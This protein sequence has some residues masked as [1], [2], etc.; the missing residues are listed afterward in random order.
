MILG[1][2]SLKGGV[3][4]GTRTC[5]CEDPAS[6]VD[7]K[8]LRESVARYEHSLLVRM[9]HNNI[10]S[11]NIM[12]PF[13]SRPVWGSGCLIMN[14][15]CGCAGLGCLY[16]VSCSGTMV[17][18]KRSK[19][20]IWTRRKTILACAVAFT[21]EE[22]DKVLLTSMYL[23]IGNSLRALPSQLGE[24]TMWRALVQVQHPSLINLQSL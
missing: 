3:S 12:V 7:Y 22:A 20:S 11:C 18:I 9:A 15:A 14:H 13:V 5:S 24:L 8:S 16:V 4:R 2:P 6:T 19:I 17:V 21:A 23:A 10:Q 1:I